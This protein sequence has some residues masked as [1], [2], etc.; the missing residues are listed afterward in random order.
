LCWELGT[1]G[2]VG[3]GATVSCRDAVLDSRGTGV[4]KGGDLQATVTVESWSLASS[5]FH[6]SDR[7]RWWQLLSIMESAVQS[8]LARSP[9]PRRFAARSSAHPAQV[10]N[11]SLWRSNF[12]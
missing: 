1:S 6:L 9:V 2:T 11:M 7:A 8:C 5:C 3:A 4:A 12:C 10:A